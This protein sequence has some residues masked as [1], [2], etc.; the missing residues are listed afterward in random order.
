MRFS[1]FVLV[2]ALI[3][4]ISSQAIAQTAAA[5]DRT[6]DSR[7]EKRLASD[8]ALKKYHIDVKVD[9]GVA[10]LTGTV[11]TE[12]ER[13][14]AAELANVAGVTRV[15]N[16]IAVDLDAA[17]HPKGTTGKAVDATKKGAE[18][19]KDTGEKVVDKTKDTGEKVVDK[20][21]EGV[22]KSGEVITDGWISSRIKTKFMGDE[23][24]R[25][26]D[27]HV[28]T[29]DHVVTLSGSVV[30]PAAHAKAIGMAREVEGVHR[31]VDKLKIVPK[32]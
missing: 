13:T 11:A 4:S 32:P 5:P 6:L 10:T 1:L 8:S 12:A 18:K 20:T 7:I 23:V 3:G 19:T 26:S 24:L 15:D 28:D 2:A 17:T 27:I 9:A 14:R 21:K 30:S 16:K 31:V 22:S 25:A 29:D